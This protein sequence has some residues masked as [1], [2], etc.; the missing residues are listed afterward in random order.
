MEDPGLLIWGR[1]MTENIVPGLVGEAQ[2]VVSEENTAKHLGSGDV[3][4]FAT[5]AMIA[6]MERASVAAVDHLLPEGQHTVG[7]RIEAQ[8]LA[9]TP[10]G[11]TVTARSELVKVEGRKLTLHVEAL[12]EREK[13]GQ[14]THQRMIVDVARFKEKVEEKARRG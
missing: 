14:G 5:P 6:L 10:L 1:G 13:I 12:D 8:H 11:M 7:I 3:S 4:V 2:T 9:A